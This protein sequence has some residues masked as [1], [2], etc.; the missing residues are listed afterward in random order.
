MCIGLSHTSVLWP[1]LVHHWGVWR[2]EGRSERAQEASQQRQAQS[3]PGTK[4]GP[5]ITVTD[6]L[7]YSK[8]VARIAGQ[9][10]VD[11]S[12]TC[13]EGDN[14]ACPC[15]RG[16]GIQS[17]TTHLN[18]SDAPPSLSQRLYCPSVVKQGSA[19]SSYLTSHEEEESGHILH[20]IMLLAAAQHAYDPSEQDDGYGHAYE[21][22]SHPL[23]VCKEKRQCSLVPS[24]CW[25]QQTSDSSD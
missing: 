6:V 20:Q 10:K 1:G 9:F 14:A 18:S 16:E 25:H 4:H 21:T 11:A 2:V 7:W 17:Q 8:H 12:H 19:L 15:Q 24:V 22:G 3:T 5:A 13:A 23:E